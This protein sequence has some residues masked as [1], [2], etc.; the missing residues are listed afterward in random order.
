VR[1]ALEP[2]RQAAARRTLQHGQPSPFPTEAG[3]N[4]AL[5]EL[6]SKFAEKRKVTAAQLAL[7]W[8]LAK[9]P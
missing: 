8:L 6:L 1:N 4:Q 3:H 7:A 5:V 9:K 2:D